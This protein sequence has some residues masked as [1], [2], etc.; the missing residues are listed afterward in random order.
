[1]KFKSSLVES[2]RDFA[3]LEMNFVDSEMDFMDSKMDFVDLGADFMDLG[4]GFVGLKIVSGDSEMNFMNLEID[5][6]GLGMDFVDGKH[7]GYFLDWCFRQVEKRRRTGSFKFIILSEESKHR[8]RLWY[9]LPDIELSE[10]MK[11]IIKMS[12]PESW[13][14]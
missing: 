2:K 12:S 9:Y 8:H 14:Y 5:F 10:N 13:K 7:L 11:E 6:M 4:V 1:M 3:D